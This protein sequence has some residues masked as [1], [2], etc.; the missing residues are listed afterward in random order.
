MN[1][2]RRK[3]R[4]L[5]END[6]SILTGVDF[7]ACMLNIPQRI[8]AARVC[9]PTR[10]PAVDTG[11]E[12]EAEEEGAELQAD[13][14]SAFGEAGSGEIGMGVQK[15]MGWL[16]SYRRSVPKLRSFS[17]WRKRWGA[18]RKRWAGFPLQAAQIR[19]P[20]QAQLELQ[21][22]WRKRRRVVRPS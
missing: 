2:I 19:R 4:V 12:A 11:A 18:A 20:Q 15:Q 14:I 9:L 6:Q 17:A 7:K 13:F 21:E 8:P 5:Y 22:K 16:T 1:D 10:V 3:P